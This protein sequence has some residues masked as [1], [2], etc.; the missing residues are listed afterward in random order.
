MAKNIQLAN[1]YSTMYV[2]EVFSQRLKDE[3][4]VCP[5]DKSLCWYRITGESI[6]NSIIFYSPWS[7]IPVHLEVGYGI[8]PLFQKPAYTSSVSYP[9]RPSSYDF[10]CTQPLVEDF[11]INAMRYAP[12][13]ADIQVYAPSR[14]GRGIYTFDSILLSKMNAVTSLEDCYRL[15]KEQR[16]SSP[17]SFLTEKSYRFSSLFIDEAIYVDDAEMYPYFAFT[18]EQALS[19]HR[20]NCQD[21]PENKV[22]QL[23]LQEWEE[24]QAALTD[25]GR[26]GYLAILEK[27]K[28]TN[29]RF[30]RK[31]FGL[32]I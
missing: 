21:N 11:P 25:G 12:F 19:Y 1:L 16:L 3:G 14:A 15:H 31:R 2:D 7:N 32:D 26:K 30:C 27:R 24:R 22:Y 23:A 17:H 5:N 6:V 28:E 18:L 13:S 10:F 29:M 8:H 4:F 9:N 20:Q